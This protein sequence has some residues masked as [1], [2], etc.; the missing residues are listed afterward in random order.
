MYGGIWQTRYVPSMLAIRVL[1][2]PTASTRPSICPNATWSPSTNGC[3]MKINAP[4]MQLLTSFCAAKP[5]ARPETPPT[6]RRPFMF[7]PSA[8]TH[9]YAVVRYTATASD[10]SIKADRACWSQ[11]TPLS[12][13]KMV[14]GGTAQT[15]HGTT[16]LEFNSNQNPR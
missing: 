8:F 2:H 12:P 10:L 9:E 6:A 14:R 5:T 7:T 13:R 3:V 4:L 16:W 11:E 1:C 15:P